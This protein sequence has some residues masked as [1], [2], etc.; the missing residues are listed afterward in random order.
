[1]FVQ[2]DVV[3]INKK[4]TVVYIFSK[5]CLDNYGK[6]NTLVKEINFFIE[7]MFM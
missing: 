5:K 2:W 3:I 6:I 1:M 7:Q 4:Y